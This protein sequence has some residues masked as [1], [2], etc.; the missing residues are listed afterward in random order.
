MST[1]CSSEPVPIPSAPSGHLPLIRGVGPG[2]VLVT[3]PPWAKSLA[4]RRR[5]NSPA[6]KTPVRN[7]LHR[8][9]S[10]AQKN[11]Y[12]YEVMT[13][14]NRYETQLRALRAVSGDL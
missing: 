2:G 10:P 12:P 6:Y 13:P 14:M 11:N 1:K 5:R 9:K 8:V 4:A 7:P 3:L